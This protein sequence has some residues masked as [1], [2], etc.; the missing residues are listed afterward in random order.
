MRSVWA[1]LAASQLHSS[2]EIL[3]P[4]MG[5]DIHGFVDIWSWIDY[6][7][8][9]SNELPWLLYEVV[10]SGLFVTLV[11]V[12]SSMVRISWLFNTVGSTNIFLCLNGFVHLTL[13]NAS[14]AR[15]WSCSVKKLD[16]FSKKCYA[17]MV[18]QLRIDYIR[19]VTKVNRVTVN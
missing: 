15:L 9:R 7:M 1:P 10:R 8:N 12:C 16:N 5:G 18:K 6:C 14:L 2:F 17:R 13:R 11:R 4:V 19:T 3:L